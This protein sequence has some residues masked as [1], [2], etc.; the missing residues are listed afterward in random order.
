MINASLTGA[1]FAG[2]FETIQGVIRKAVVNE[3][4]RNQ[5]L[6][7]AGSGA[8]FPDLKDKWTRLIA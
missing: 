1:T 7:D 8:K 2:G 4:T 6:K 5:A 3:T